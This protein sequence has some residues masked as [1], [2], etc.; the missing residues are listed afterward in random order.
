[1]NV[2]MLRTACCKIA[3]NETTASR[4]MRFAAA[5]LS[6]SVTQLTC[7]FDQLSSSSP[8]VPQVLPLG[9]FVEDY[10]QVAAVD[11]C[12]AAARQAAADVCRT[13]HDD[14][15]A[16]A[17]RLIGVLLTLGV[18]GIARLLGC[19]LT[20]GTNTAVAG[21][22]FLPLDEAIL[23]S[24]FN[25][26][27]HPSAKISVGARALSKHLGRDTSVKFWGSCLHGSEESKNAQ[28]AVVLQT[29]LNDV[30]WRNVHTLPH[31]VTAFEVRCSSGYGARWA[32][33]SSVAAAWDDAGLPEVD[34][35]YRGVT[36]RGFLEPHD[37]HGHE[38]GW[39]H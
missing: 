9:M 4:Q 38:N 5:Q 30:V 13:S 20:A 23:I 18:T 33:S 35:L 17:F 7:L 39:I 1:M 29:L 22:G 2:D 6:A 10:L 28:A 27:H 11:N 25:A 19:R 24:A 36:F 16:Q 12:V 14:H 31:D 37:P 26:L 15:D 32:V 8:C 21:L 3:A 34:A